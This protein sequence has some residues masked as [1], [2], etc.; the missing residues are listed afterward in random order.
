MP[1][2]DPRSGLRLNIVWPSSSAL[3]VRSGYPVTHAA[4]FRADLH[5]QSSLSTPLENYKRSCREPRSLGEAWINDQ[6][7]AQLLNP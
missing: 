4:P 1:R 7:N 6:L 5:S 3:E 2:L